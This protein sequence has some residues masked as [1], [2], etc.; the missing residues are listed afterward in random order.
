MVYLGCFVVENELGNGLCKLIID[1]ND[2]IVGCYMLGNLVLEIIVVVGIVIQ[3]G[4]MVDEFR[5]SVFLYLIVGEI[6]YEILFV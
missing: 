6:Y 2:W 1:Y 4:Y 5:K 3:R